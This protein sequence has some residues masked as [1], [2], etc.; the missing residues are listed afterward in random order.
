VRP[1]TLNDNVIDVHSD[2]ITTNNVIMSQA[3]AIQ[4][5]SLG[6]WGGGFYINQSYQG[7][8]DSGPLSEM[9]IKESEL[10]NI[11]VGADFVVVSISS[12]E[13]NALKK[14]ERGQTESHAERVQ[15]TSAS[16]GHLSTLADIITTYSGGSQQQLTPMSI[17]LTESSFQSF[18]DFTQS[19]AMT[20]ISR[21]IFDGRRPTS[22]SDVMSPNTNLTTGS[23]VSSLSVTPE[24][25]SP[26]DGV[27]PSKRGGPPKRPGVF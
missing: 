17:G 21:G 9:I 26:L 2:S 23:A 27:Q 19:G 15:A 13:Y 10:R 14:W 11:N 7:R 18:D 5:D 8:M 16:L 22:S 20:R 6:P 3:W 4:S 12:E 1:V 24:P 25:V